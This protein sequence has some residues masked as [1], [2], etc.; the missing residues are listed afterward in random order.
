VLRAFERLLL[1]GERTTLA[2]VVEATRLTAEQVL[3]IRRGWGLADPP[4][5]V[6]S[7]T[8]AEIAALES[9]RNMAGFVGPE[10]AMHVARVMGTAMSRLAEAEIALVRSRVE[11]PMIER[12]ESGASILQAYANVFDVFLPACL[13]TL[14]LLHRSHLVGIG[15]RY[16]E[17]TLPPSEINVVDTIVGFADVTESTRLVQET[18]L[19]GLDRAIT[20]FERIT[21]DCWRPPARPS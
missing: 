20:A 15:R 21:S 8:P 18:D 19:E 14:D 7:F 17:G 10:L 16:S 5:D 1:P 3:T 12:H 2:N 4:P 6:A 13:R 11:A 9:V